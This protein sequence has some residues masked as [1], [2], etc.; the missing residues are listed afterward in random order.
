MRLKFRATKY[1]QPRSQG[2]LA[3]AWERGCH[4]GS[5]N[6]KASGLAQKDK[7]AAELCG[8]DGPRMT[9]FPPCM[10]TGTATGVDKAGRSGRQPN[11]RQLE[12]FVYAS[13]LCLCAVKSTDIRFRRWVAVLSVHY[14]VRHEHKIENFLKKEDVS[15]A[16]GA[17]LEYPAT[18]IYY[19]LFLVCGRNCRG[20]MAP[21]S[22]CLGWR[23]WHN[24]TCL[25]LGGIHG[26]GWTFSLCLGGIQAGG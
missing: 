23:Q 15:S 25:C 22:L 19:F 4:V 11:D 7:M 20:I 24:W 26:H 12:S 9:C 18:L 14:F 1:P 3:P 5:G 16:L 13:K 21:L 10:I 8:N 6:V 2:L 17:I